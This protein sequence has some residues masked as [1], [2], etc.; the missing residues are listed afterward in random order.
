[1]PEDRKKIVRWLM[2]LIKQAEKSREKPKEDKAS[3]ISDLIA[4]SCFCADGKDTMKS[5][6][7][8]AWGIKTNW[9][10]VDGATEC[11]FSLI[12]GLPLMILS[13]PNG[14]N[15][16]IGTVVT[17]MENKYDNAFRADGTG[18][19]H[20]P[21]NIKNAL[22][23]PTLKEVIAFVNELDPQRFQDNYQITLI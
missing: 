15:Y 10:A 7:E 5:I 2:S 6:I 23:Y 17:L 9:E 4:N 19:N 1:M 21:V 18:G 12:K 22:R 14:H 3:V 8:V 13:R 11:Q 20:L 16:D